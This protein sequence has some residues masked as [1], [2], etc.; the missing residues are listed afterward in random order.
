M[1]DSFTKKVLLCLVIVSVV[2]PY[3][4]ITH[5]A[6]VNE[7][8]SEYCKSKGLVLRHVH[9]KEY[10][11]IDPETGQMFLPYETANKLLKDNES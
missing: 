1:M 6:R 4:G 8:K 3:W 11:C 7:R 5:N 9:R 10:A 2:I